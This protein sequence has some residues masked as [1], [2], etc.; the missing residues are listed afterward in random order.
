MGHFCLL[1]V[2]TIIVHGHTCMKIK[3]WD[4]RLIFRKQYIYF[5]VSWSLYWYV[6]L[7]EH[8]K[9]TYAICVPPHS[10]LTLQ[11]IVKAWLF[12]SDV[13]RCPEWE[14]RAHLGLNDSQASSTKTGDIPN[15]PIGTSAL[16][17]KLDID[18]LISVSLL[19][20]PYQCCGSWSSRIQCFWV[21][22]NRFRIL[23]PETDPCK[24]IFLVKNTV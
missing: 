12:S 13:L 11:L 4:Y 9:D 6:W 23:S 7:N 8:L 20:V 24:Y 22:R 10:S 16:S 15:R 21:S 17:D 3:I 14:Q 2:K 18:P 19:H 5:K 1:K